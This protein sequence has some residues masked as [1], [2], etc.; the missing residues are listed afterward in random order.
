M[1][2]P[3]ALLV[4]RRHTLICVVVRVCGGES[5][6][7]LLTQTEGAEWGSCWATLSPLSLQGEEQSGR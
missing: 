2:F 5:K 6:E 7:R 1:V 3:G 4:T